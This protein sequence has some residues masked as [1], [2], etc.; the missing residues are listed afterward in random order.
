ML[1]ALFRAFLMLLPVSGW[2]DGG[3]L[4]NFE[5]SSQ[6]LIMKRRSWGIALGPT[7]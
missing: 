2:S 4:Q 7:E 1:I 6:H 3:I 5:G